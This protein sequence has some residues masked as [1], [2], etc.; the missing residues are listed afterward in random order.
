M[1]CQSL[2]TSLKSS[3]RL[4]APRGE[5]RHGGFADLASPPG[6]LTSHSSPCLWDR[7]TSWGCCT[8]E[9]SGGYGCGSRAQTAQS[10]PGGRQK[11]LGR[12]RDSGSPLG[13]GPQGHRLWCSK[14]DFGN[15][16]TCTL[17][18]GFQNLGEDG[19]Q[20]KSRAFS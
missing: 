8:S 1:R 18:A 7:A 11:H 16:D 6:Q 2:G 10:K 14:L 20:A 12:S 4:L 19:M 15:Q 13:S 5:A 9:A 17:P 3:F